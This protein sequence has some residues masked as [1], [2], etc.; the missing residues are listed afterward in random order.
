MIRTT[1]S[2]G[3]KAGT[4][5]MLPPTPIDFCVVEARAKT[6]TAVFE[7][8][9]FDW[10]TLHEASVI[11]PSNYIELTDIRAVG[12]YK[13]PRH[14]PWYPLGSVRYHPAGSE[15]QCR[16]YED[17]QTTFMCAFDPE[18][19]VGDDYRVDEVLLT[20][21][22][23]LKN[24]YLQQ[25]LCRAKQEVKNPGL[26]SDVVLE[27]LSLEILNEWRN[28]FFIA[29][30]KSLKRGRGA[31]LNER[32]IADIVAMIRERRCAPTLLELALVHNLSVRHFSRLFKQSTGENI[33]SVCKRE[34][35]NR[36]KDMLLNSTLLIKEVAYQCGF[37]TSSSFC[38][39][40]RETTGRSPEDYRNNPQCV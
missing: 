16:W 29:S 23:D 17:K 35:L 1:L 30:P 6:S 10:S 40:F 39:A 37:E 25:L 22:H 34:R 36:A 15:F 21:A 13:T 32:E 7:L 14:S 2:S 18:T 11:P 4:N 31:Q 19:V 9:N 38:K 26:V 24:N 5:A 28:E 33:S 12:R 27:A 20:K 8:R 3:Y